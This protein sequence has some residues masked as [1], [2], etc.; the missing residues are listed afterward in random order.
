MQGDN[1]KGEC[2]SFANV[3]SLFNIRNNT[4]G[5][6]IQEYLLLGL[7]VVT[8]VALVVSR[9]YMYSFQKYIDTFLVTPSDYS[10]IVRDIPDSATKEDLEEM[11]DE[12]RPFLSEEEKQ[13]TDN[14]SVVRILM[15]NDV[16]EYLK[17]KRK[18]I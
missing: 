14:L 18:K 10:L 12:M 7:I 1:C 15:I 6:I 11:V 13:Q 2:D 9:C 17:E 3:V 8:I 16:T 4:T 5:V